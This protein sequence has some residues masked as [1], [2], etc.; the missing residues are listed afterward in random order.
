VK[1][2]TITLEVG[3]AWDHNSF[4]I[5]IHMY[6]DYIGLEEECNATDMVAVNYLYY[7]YYYY[8]S[9]RIFTFRLFI[10]LLLLLLFICFE[11]LNICFC[12]YLKKIAF[13]IIFS[14]FGYDE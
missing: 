2:A 9:L 11:Y 7:Y 5:F 6:L 8:S 12:S 3:I 1:F 4:N 13:L 10:L 14:L